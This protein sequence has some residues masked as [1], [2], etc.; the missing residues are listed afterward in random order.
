MS[1]IIPFKLVFMED[2]EAWEYVYYDLLLDLLFFVDMIIRFNT[3]IYSQGRLITDRKTIAKTYAK[4]WFVLDLLCLIP[5]SYLRK[6]SEH[7][8]RG[9]NE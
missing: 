8:P 4:S 7:W 6:R 1:F 3:P 5:I 9:K 2:K